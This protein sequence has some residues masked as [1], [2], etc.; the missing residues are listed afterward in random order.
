MVTE[1]SAHSGGARRYSSVSEEAGSGLPVL[2]QKS[3]LCKSVLS[4]GH[5]RAGSSV[6]FGAGGIRGL[7]MQGVRG[8]GSIGGGR[9]GGGGSCMSESL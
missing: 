9:G 8:V 5:Q 4:V 6:G 7:A 2:D 3:S 1:C